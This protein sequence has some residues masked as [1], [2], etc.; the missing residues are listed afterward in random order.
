MVCLSQSGRSSAHCPSGYRSDPPQ[1]PEAGVGPSQGPSP[2]VQRKEV[3]YSIPCAECP[4]AYIGQTGRSLDLC[5]QEHR[6]ALKKGDVTAS[7]VA[8][9]VFEVG[10]QVDLSKA[11]VIDYHPHAQARCLLESW[12]IE[13][14]Q[15]PPQQREGPHV[16]TICNSVGLTGV[17]SSCFSLFLVCSINLTCC[18]HFPGFY[19][20]LYASRSHVTIPI[21]TPSLVSLFTDE[22]SWRLPKRLIYF[23]NSSG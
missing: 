3:V 13:H 16:R 15:A 23:L 14:H 5:L 4:G 1:D 12:H 21:C 18:V 19:Y 20:F 2:G 11:S 22:G 10:H 6:R 9:H 7:A 8:E 17:L